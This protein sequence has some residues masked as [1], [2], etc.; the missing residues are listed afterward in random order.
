MADYDVIVIGGGAAGLSAAGLLA[1][2]G[3]KVLLLEKSNYF[4]GRASQ[5]DDEGFRVS[6]GGHLMEDPG[7][8]I[9]RIAKEIGHSIEVGPI[10]TNMAVWDHETMKWGSI[11]DRYSGANRTD[12]KA[13]IKVLEE[14]PYEAFEEWDDR[15][16]RDWLNQYTRDPGVHDLFE[17]TTLLE[18]MTERWHEHSASDN[19]YVRKLHYGEAKK[20]GYSFWPKGG[21]DGIF[22]GLA[23]AAK[24]RGAEIHLGKG[25]SRVLVENEK[26]KGVFVPRGAVLSNT[27][28]EED[29]ITADHVISTVGVWNVLDIVPED[30]L[31]VWYAEQIKFLAQDKFRL[32]LIGLQIAT[33]EPCPILDRQELSAYLHTPRA[34]LSGFLFEQTAMDPT[35]APDGMFLYTMGGVIPGSRGRDQTWLRKTMDDYEADMTDMYPGF[36]KAVWRRRSLI[37]NPPF[38]VVQM[39]GLVGKYRPHWRA[40]NVE[41]LW[42]ASETFR[43]RMIG[44]DRSARAALTVVE[45]ILGRRLWSMDETWRY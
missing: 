19:L 3:K 36:E 16:L 25:V 11:R 14:T 4:G 32:A 12:L 34:R 15:P 43:S 2:E 6:L 18:C 28:W 27:M 22:A 10:S 13:V 42:F 9:M 31:P 7:S 23:A 24:A 8:G 45:E 33:E 17:F 44:T 38:G 5:V 35:T 21:W 30:V 1:K 37:F 26:V 39:P 41:G 20:G 40:P 29:L